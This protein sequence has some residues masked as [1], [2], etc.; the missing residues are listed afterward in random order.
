MAVEATVNNVI[1]GPESLEML[2]RVLD[3]SFKRIAER[4][5]EARMQEP[6]RIRLAQIIVHAFN[7][8]EVDPVKLKQI[9]VAR[10]SPSPED[11][12]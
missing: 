6:I 9:A 11:I 2:C 4:P 10:Y 5:L 3:E 7:D 1:I 8:G 12:G